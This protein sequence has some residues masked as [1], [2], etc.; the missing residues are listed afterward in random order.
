MILDLPSKTCRDMKLSLLGLKISRDTE[1]QLV[2]I[3]VNTI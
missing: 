2:N 1:L 3:F